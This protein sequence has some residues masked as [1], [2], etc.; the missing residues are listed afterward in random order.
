[1]SYTIK[2]KEEMSRIDSTKSEMIAELS[3][4][5]RNNAHLKNNNLLV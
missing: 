1:M 4:F 5:V 3:G 2:I